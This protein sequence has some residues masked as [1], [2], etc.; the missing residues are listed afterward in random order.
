MPGTFFLDNQDT[1]RVA[2]LQVPAGLDRVE[3]MKFTFADEEDWD[4]ILELHGALGIDVLDSGKV[5]SLL[6]SRTI[7]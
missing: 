1:Y 3:E 6:D 7:K 5:G 2:M 4:N